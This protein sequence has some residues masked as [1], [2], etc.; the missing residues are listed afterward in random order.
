M[1]S[2]SKEK[3]AAA[4]RKLFRRKLAAGE[5]DAGNAASTNSTE[6][7]ARRLLRH[8][9]QPVDS[10]PKAQEMRTSA[11]KSRSEATDHHIKV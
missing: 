5:G 4:F 1:T 9:V 6:S 10:A 11:A 7:P 8:A 2:R 3:V